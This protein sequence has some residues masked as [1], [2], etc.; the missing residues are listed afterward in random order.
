MTW[1]K[2]DVLN[3]N[4]NFRSICHFEKTPSQRDPRW[5][6]PSH[7]NF[8]G[9][10]GS[11]PEKTLCG[12]ASW[13]AYLVGGWPTPLKNDGVKVIWDMLGWW[14]S[15]KK[16]GKKHV[17]KH[18]P[19]SV[20]SSAW[21]MMNHPQILS[22]ASCSQRRLPETKKGVTMKRWPFAKW[23]LLPLSSVLWTLLP[24]TSS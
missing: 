13:P 20:G 5:L 17:P 18:Q 10:N 11:N 3:L 14:H 9:W 1:F 15:Q 24:A 8:W 23:P 21:C 22:Q 6:V 19:V 2:M 16:M 7:N 12:T 4:W